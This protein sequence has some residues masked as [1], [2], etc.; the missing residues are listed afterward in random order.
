MLAGMRLNLRE[1]A[2]YQIEPLHAGNVL[3]PVLDS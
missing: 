2:E 1:I 3:W